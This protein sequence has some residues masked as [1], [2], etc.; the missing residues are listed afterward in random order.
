VTLR[1]LGALAVAVLVAP[2]SHARDDEDAS[3]DDAALALADLSLDELMNVEVETASKVG[4]PLWEEAAAVSVVTAEDIRHYG[5]RS[6]A[7]VLDAQLGFSTFSD[8]IYDFVVSRG[9]YL[10]NDPNSRIL[11]LLDGH[12][13]LEFFGYYNGQLPT[14][15]L[16]HVERIEIVRG[17]NSVLYGTNAMFAVINVITRR[18]AD[19]EGVMLSGGAGSHRHGR[20]ALA[21]GTSPSDSL[22]VVVRGSLQTTGYQSLYFDEYDVA[23]Y[24]TDPTSVPE[25]N[26]L[27]RGEMTARIEAGPL[28]I[29]GLWHQ[30]RKYVPTGL[31]GG[32]ID[33]A[34]TYFQDTNRHL[35]AR[36]AIPTPDPVRMALR[37]YL[38]DY[39]FDGQFTYLADPS[40]ETGPPYEHEINEIA[41]TSYGAEWL[42]EIAWNK[43]HRTTAGVDLRFLDEVSFLYRSVE[44]GGSSLNETADLDLNRWYGALYAQHRIRPKP[45][46]T[47][48]A[49]VHLDLV[50]KVGAHPSLRGNVGFRPANR[51]W[52]YVLYGEAFRTPNIWETHGGFFIEGNPELDPEILRM[53]EI[54]LRSGLSRHVA[55]SGHTFLYRLERH[56]QADTETGGFANGPGLWGGGFE[57]ELRVRTRPV[58]GYLSGTL[59]NARDEEEEQRIS[60]AP[61]WVVKGGVVVAVWHRRIHLGVESRVV[62]VRLLGDPSQPA[63]LPYNVTNVTLGTTDL[64][65]YF[66]VSVSVYNVFGA[67]IEHPSFVPDLASWNLNATYPMYDI[68]AD[69][70]T[71]LV[72]IHLWAGPRASAIGK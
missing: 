3:D 59:T 43:H 69:G 13:I 9:F 72:R 67:T 50:E 4:T 35:E 36:L 56:I 64:T 28:T 14:I 42:T 45:W 65:P 6:L 23:G 1:V 11:L 16:D 58:H 2:S 48:E 68:P 19:I 40:W 41:D 29:Q 37:A 17:P 39:R 26:R 31:Y 52:I 55:L 32:R 18:G 5:W 63:D 20:V 34:E 10:S 27:L 24:P 54:V 33:V 53:G 38:D 15:D 66:D 57:A 25:A 71:L 22:D 12:P 61:G 49:G 30:R 62:G 47:M 21:V 44:D 70:R 46:F 51:T 8:R 7:D 60:F